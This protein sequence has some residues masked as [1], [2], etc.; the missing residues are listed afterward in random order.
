MS[1]DPSV[2]FF[3]RGTPKPGGSKRAIYNK[4]QGRS[5]IVPDNKGTKPW[6]ETV[7]WQAIEH[8]AE[9]KTVEDGQ[10]PM[11]G[12]VR[13]ILDFVLQRP[14]NH[15]GTGRNADRLKSS[16][17]ERHHKQTPDLDKLCR[18]T[19][20]ALKAILWNDDKQ[21][22]ILLTQKVWTDS[23]PGTEHAGVYVRVSGT[24]E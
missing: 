15:Y 9:A 5:F 22:A 4:K 19:L 21:V 14:K 20:D 17:P 3:V 8:L 10:F 1:D 7:K 23:G 18:S 11:E 2:Q 13:V 6:M 12:T 16:A 24:K